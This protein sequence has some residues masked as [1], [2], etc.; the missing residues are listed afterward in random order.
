MSAISGINT[1]YVAP[2]TSSSPDDVSMGKEDFLKL[3]VAQLENQ[4]PMNPSD[5]TE[6]TAQLAQFSQL[7]QL[8]NMNES[9]EGMTAM[10]N[11]MER[12]SA[13]GLIGQDVVAQSNSFR[14]SGD[15][16]ELG[17]RLELPADDVKLHVLSQTGST[18]ATITPSETEMGDHF[19]SWD[20]T[21]DFG[22][23][24]EAG[25]Y[26][27]VVRALD[28]DD[29]VVSSQSL[30]KGRVMGVD[31][32]NGSQLETSAGIFSMSKVERAGALL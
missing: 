23:P 9:L 24:L 32:S 31:M 25:D 27:L 8:T 10:S 21:S 17:Y 11:E 29:K 26:Q 19:I 22:M 1:G 15:P 14:F 2:T 6:F 12:M 18:L 5:P 20:G 7:E 4:D 13:L 3:L 30:L 28:K 16:V